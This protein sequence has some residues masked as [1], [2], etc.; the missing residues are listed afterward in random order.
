MY[1]MMNGRS[2]P[3]YRRYEWKCNAL[4]CRRAAR[5]SGWGSATRASSA[6][7][8]RQ[9]GRN[10]DTAWFARSMLKWPGLREA[11]SK[12]AFPRQF[13]TQSASSAKRLGDLTQPCAGIKRRR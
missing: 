13:R 11:L 8:R 10:R 9:K 4:T 3:E 1:L 2:R 12:R 6:G 5:H 7:A